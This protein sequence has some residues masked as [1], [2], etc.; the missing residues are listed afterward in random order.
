VAGSGSGRLRDGK[1]GRAGR[2]RRVRRGP[3]GWPPRGR[4][5][6]RVGGIASGISIT[7]R[8]QAEAVAITGEPGARRRGVEERLII[9]TFKKSIRIGILSS[10]TNTITADSGAEMLAWGR[11]GLRNRRIVKGVSDFNK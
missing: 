5:R 11:K 7:T 8:V 1:V 4:V 9:G 2:V 10:N 6:A 3:L